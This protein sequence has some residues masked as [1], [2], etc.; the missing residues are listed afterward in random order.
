MFSLTCL[1]Y[2]NIP[3]SKGL[4]PTIITVY[5]IVLLFDS[6]SACVSVEIERLVFPVETSTESE[7]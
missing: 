5:F 7:V 1:Q 6:L 3:A 4:F 2:C